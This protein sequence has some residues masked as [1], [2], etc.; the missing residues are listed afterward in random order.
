MAGD[1]R[2]WPGVSVE[3]EYV[4]VIIFKTERYVCALLIYKDKMFDYST[5]L[6]F[7][8]GMLSL[9]NSSRSSEI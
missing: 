5:Q 2:E 3:R 8:H 7:I 1:G 4:G 6:Q 9:F